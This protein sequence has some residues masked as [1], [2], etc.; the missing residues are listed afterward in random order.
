MDHPDPLVIAATYTDFDRLAHKPKGTPSSHGLYVYRLNPKTSQLTLLSVAKE[1]INPAFLRFHPA[2]NVLYAC[3]E[4]ISE[5]GEVVAYSLSPSTGMLRELGPR[6]STKGMSTCY[7]TIDRER[8]H[9]LFVN[10]WDSSLGSFPMSQTGVLS[11]MCCFLPMEDKGS[12]AG[13]EKEVEDDKADGKNHS[14]DCCP[15]SPGREDH[16]NNR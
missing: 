11:E 14:T 8:E 7:L 6:Q 9:L 12:S 5:P 1:V 16:L 10:Y 13:K 15:A 2:Y 3:T 4:S